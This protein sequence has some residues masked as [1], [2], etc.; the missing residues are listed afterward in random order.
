MAAIVRVAQG[1]N[2]GSATATSFTL[3]LPAARQSGDLLIALVGSST[4]TAPTRPGTWT[5]IRAIADAASHLDVMRL[6]EAGGA[7]PVWSKTTACKWAGVVVCIAAGT[8]DTGTPVDV[9]NG[10]NHTAATATLHTS[11][12]ATVVT[13]NCLLIGGFGT[14][15]AATW[16]TADANPVM[17]LGAQTNSTGTNPAS[18][19]VFTS[20]TNPASVGSITRSATASVSSA[21]ACMWIAAIRPDPGG[22]PGGRWVGVPIGTRRLRAAHRASTW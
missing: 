18:V 15:A 11:P 10:V 9:E 13:D 19:A 12:S 7:A 22:T 16:T 14:K 6:T 20:G 8:W 3:T 17:L 21:E 2:S 1:N 4:T 5:G